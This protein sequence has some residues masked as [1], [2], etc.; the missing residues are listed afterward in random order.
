MLLSRCNLTQLTEAKR[1][2]KVQL[3]DRIVQIL[4]VLF[5]LANQAG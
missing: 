4:G 2:R 3:A 5:R 1:K